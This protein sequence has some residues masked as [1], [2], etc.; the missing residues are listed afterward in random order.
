[1]SAYV[2]ARNLHLAC[3]VLSLGGFAARGALMLA[4]SPLLQARFVRIAPHFVDTLLLASALWLSW[5]LGQYPFVD[6]WLT[7]KVLGLLAYIVLGAVALRRGS[8]LAVRATAFAG[9]LLA[10][11]YIVAVALTRNPF[12]S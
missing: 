5:M 11:A 4:G 1:M 6:G 10:A 7:A 3:V 2:L 12:L 8:S 9:A